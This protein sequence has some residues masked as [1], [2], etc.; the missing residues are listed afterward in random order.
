M[1]DKMAI[2]VAFDPERIKPLV[3]IISEMPKH[4][5]LRPAS[6]ALL[7]NMSVASRVIDQHQKRSHCRS[8]RAFL[9]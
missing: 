7:A 3:T 6:A 5:E 8:F 9:F 2:L 4:E 1:E